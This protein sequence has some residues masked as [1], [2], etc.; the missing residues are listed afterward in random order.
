MNGMSRDMRKNSMVRREDRA[1]T[2]ERARGRS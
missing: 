1:S 2:I